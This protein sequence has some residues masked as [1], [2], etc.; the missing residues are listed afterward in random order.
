[1]GETLKAQ[2]GGDKGWVSTTALLQGNAS[3]VVT[4]RK[5]KTVVRRAGAGLD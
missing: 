2:K 5:R 1:V 3:M 4:G